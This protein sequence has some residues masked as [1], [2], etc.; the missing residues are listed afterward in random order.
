MKLL[1]CSLLGLG[2]LAF[3][4]LGSAADNAKAKAKKKEFGEEYKAPLIQPDI[5]DKIKFTPEQKEKVTA[6][7][8]EF[9]K[10]NEEALASG[11]EVDLKA[12]EDAKKAKADGDK[13]AAAKAT[14]EI[15]KARL[16]LD[17]LR[18]DYE[19]KFLDLLTEAQKKA[20]DNARAGLPVE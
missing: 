13:A 17:K 10:K 9:D 4:A 5:L 15:K 3:V 11:K 7:L 6:L 1:R 19:A 18:K 14:A 12:K 2:L 8:K 20:Y 16:G